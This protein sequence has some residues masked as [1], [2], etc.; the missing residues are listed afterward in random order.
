MVFLQSIFSECSTVLPVMIQM[1]HD[2]T[3]KTSIKVECKVAKT[4][5]QK[6]RRNELH[7]DGLGEGVAGCRVAQVKITP[8]PL[9][10]Q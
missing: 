10:L 8:F 4:D 7:R 1:C 3:S 6:A 2:F 5:V 9:T